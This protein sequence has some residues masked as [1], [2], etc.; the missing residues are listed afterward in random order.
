MRKHKN[1]VGAKE[2]FFIP[3]IYMKNPYKRNARK[4]FRRNVFLVLHPKIVFFCTQCLSSQC[5]FSILKVELKTMTKPHHHL[6]NNHHYFRKKIL[7]KL[8]FGAFRIPFSWI[9]FPDN[10]EH[11]FQ[12]ILVAFSI[13]QWVFSIYQNKSHNSSWCRR[14]MG[15]M[16]NKI[17]RMRR[18]ENERRRRRRRRRKRRGEEGKRVR[19]KG[20]LT[21]REKEG[22]KKKEPSPNTTN[23]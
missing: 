21:Q 14:V 13:Y 3:W 10:S 6:H 4:I 8:I 11:F 23:N 7:K 16:L 22:G 18:E 2:V 19:K 15:T 9:P 5:S 12:T 20:N 17:I 1:E